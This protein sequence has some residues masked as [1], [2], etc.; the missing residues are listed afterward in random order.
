MRLRVDPY[1]STPAELKIPDGAI[2][3][4]MTVEH[5]ILGPA[6]INAEYLL[7]MIPASL[8]TTTPRKFWC[9]IHGPIDNHNARMHKNTIICSQCADEYLDNLENLRDQVNLFDWKEERY[10]GRIR[11]MQGEI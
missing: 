5:G 4:N 7:P 3:T 8:T 9:A 2:I 10:K 6:R 1:G 11:Q